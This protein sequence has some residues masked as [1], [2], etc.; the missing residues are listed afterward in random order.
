[1]IKF[2]VS[3]LS[4]CFQLLSHCYPQSFA[5]KSGP[6]FFKRY[7]GPILHLS[8]SA[9]TR[10][11]PNY[12][13]KKPTVK[14]SELVHQIS[15]AIKLRRSE[16]VCRVLKPYES[17]FRS[18]HLIWVLMNIKGEYRLVLD[19]F[20]WACLRR[21]PTLEARCIVIQIAVA[22]KDLKMAHQLIHDFWS[23]P[24]L[25]IGL[26]FSYILERLIY[27]YKD[28][29]SD[30]KVFDVFFQVLVE[31]GLLDEGKKL[32]DKM[33]NYGLIISVDSLN[34]YLSKLRDHFDG[35]WRAIKVFFELPDVGICWNIASYNIII[36][37]LCQLGKIK[38]SHRLLLQMELRGCIP[39]VVTYSTIIDGY[40]HVGRLQMVLRLIDE[41]Q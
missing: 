38:E 6:P 10:P 18:D 21:D 5:P 30:P 27:T 33:L 14:D 12:S 24:D 20:E 37:S 16:P 23:K 3:S 2:A 41:M 39:D 34:I 4:H 11:F 25:D 22:S 36:H 13:P 40:C 7:L 32:F 26:S 35:F 17:K 28:W 31:V 15:N 29:G 8:D 19:F 9:N 1:M